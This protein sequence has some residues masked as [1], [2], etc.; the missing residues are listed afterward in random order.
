MINSKTKAAV[1]TAAVILI[2]AAA[3]TAAVL[4]G[5]DDD[6]DK[7][8]THYNISDTRVLEGLDR[9]LT[10]YY[11]AP[12]EGMQQELSDFLSELKLYDHV[13]VT[14]INSAETP[15]LAEAL[16]ED[17]NEVENGDMVI[18]Y[19]GKYSETITADKLTDSNGFIG[20]SAVAETV[21]RLCSE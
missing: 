14:I 3:V 4:L 12:P 2:A 17:G 19:S 1:I 15:S 20:E 8:G 16:S 13:S 9:T 18:N 7:F 11:L 10:F 5:S 21:R 6:K